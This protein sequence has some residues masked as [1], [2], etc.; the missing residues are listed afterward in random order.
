MARLVLITNLAAL[1][2]ALGGCTEYDSGKGR[3]TAR[4]VRETTDRHAVIAAAQDKEVDTVEGMAM[5]RRAYRESL[6]ALIKHYKN[7]GNYMKRQWAE[8][9]LETLD[10]IPQYDY[11]IEASIA[12][13]DLKASQEIPEADD[14]YYEALV[15]EDEANKL[16][17]IKNE[18]LLRLALDRYNSLIRDYPK[19]DKID[20]AAY[21]AAKIYQGFKD[22]SIAALYYQRAFQWDPETVYPARYKAAY[23]FDKK[24]HQRSE[25]LELY[26]QAL[27]L[28]PLNETQKQIAN[29][30]V[31][32]LTTSD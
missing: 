14:L 31:A 11:I 27:E 20:D 7:T 15:L 22:Y 17:L 5:H 13:P 10:T 1:V 24:L 19:S 29:E 30:R 16:I 9:E 32:E 21:R 3:L 23:I 28:D 6:V 12:G 26:Q 25:A 4:N 8:K 2:I 18:D